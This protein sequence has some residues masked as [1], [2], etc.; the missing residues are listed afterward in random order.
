M[1]NSAVFND[2]F[3]VC[4]EVYVAARELVKSRVATTQL[5]SASKFLWR[6]DVRPRLVEYVADFARAGERALGETSFCAGSSPYRG[7]SGAR[8][9]SNASSPAVFLGPTTARRGRADT[10]CRTP[11]GR[12]DH[13]VFG[14][15]KVPRT[16][17]LIL[18]RMY[19]LGGAE[20]AAARL[21]LGLSER[22]WSDWAEEIRARV[23]AELIRAHMYPPARYFGQTSAKRAAQLASTNAAP[24]AKMAAVPCEPDFA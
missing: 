14:A 6:P 2:V 22:T 5:Q 17:R 9:P 1:R 12:G 20:Y 7:R 18:F 16:S 11:K 19:Y 3:L 21:L 24:K 4:H 15:K 8:Q 13:G 10:G 23:G